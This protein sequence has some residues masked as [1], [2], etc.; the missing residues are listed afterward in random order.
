M[1]PVGDRSLRNFRT[2]SSG[3]RPHR[4][5]RYW[6][7]IAA[8]VIVTSCGGGS[9]STPSPPSLDVDGDGR[10][11]LGLAITGSANDGGYYESLV[12]AVNRFARTHGYPDVLVS[13][14][15]RS[16]TAAE[17]LEALARRNVDL[18]I[19]S[20]SEIAAP[21][22]DL[23]ARYRKLFWYCNCGE[24]FESIRGLARTL[25]DRTEIAFT[26]GYAAGLLMAE[27]SG[28]TLAFIGCCDLPFEKESSLAT[29]AG[30]KAIDST[31]ELR[32]LPSG[33]FKYDF[34]N[35]DGALAA[36]ERA[37]SAGA[38]A[39]DPFLSGAHDVVAR[40]AAADGLITMSA[41]RS[42]ACSRTD[43]RYSIA[44][45]FDSSDYLPS[46]LEKIRNG[47]LREGRSY[48]FRVGVD[49]EPGAVICRA[50]PEAASAMQRLSQD[51]AAGRY[52]ATFA[53]I[54]TKAYG[55]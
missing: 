29:E 25:D 8:G 38:I 46:A 47:V 11:Q 49:P 22:P 17:R 43:L 12:A 28:R 21:L 7:M 20:S 15:I 39:V 30:L 9:S 40:Q 19:V 55:G 27:R 14:G 54:R 24:G 26:A 18:M 1:A 10:V 2:M 33:A 35:V 42:D 13:D 45:R 52:T 16:E 48:T 37:R 31:F 50:T 5:R 41:G 53:E 34:G 23:T 3:S 6:S 51:I 44:V 4:M 32:Y 36:Y